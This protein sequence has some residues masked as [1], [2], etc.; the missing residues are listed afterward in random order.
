[1]VLGTLVALLLRNLARPMRVLVTAGL[2]AAW[3]MPT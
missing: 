1:M 2:V 3:A